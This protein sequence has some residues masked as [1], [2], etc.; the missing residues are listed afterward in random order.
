MPAETKIYLL[1]PKTTCSWGE[2]LLSSHKGQH[3]TVAVF[4]FQGQ[5]LML[6]KNFPASLFLLRKKG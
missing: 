5:T 4:Y 1:V 6:K 2:T 3:K